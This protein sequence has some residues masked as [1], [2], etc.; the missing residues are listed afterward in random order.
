MLMVFIMK[1]Q[2][3][4]KMRDKYFDS[5]KGAAILAVVFIHCSAS[6]SFFEPGSINWY[7]GFLLRQTLNFAVPVFLVFAGF[8]AAQKP[9]T[10]ATHFYL[11]RLRYMV[12]AYLFWTLICVAIKNPKH[13][14]SP[15]ELMGDV[16]LGQGIG[17]GYFVVVLI[18]FTLLHP[19]LIK[20]KGLWAQLVLMALGFVLAMVLNYGIRINHPN[21]WLAQFPYYCLPFI[22][23]C[24][25]YQMGLF[26]AQQKKLGADLGLGRFAFSSLAMMLTVFIFASVVE[27][28]YWAQHGHYSFGI[29]QIK[30]SGFL[31]ST[32]WSALALKYFK[33]SASCKGVDILLSFMFRTC[34][35]CRWCKAY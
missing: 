32:V 22:V 23:W 4:P 29:S 17:I 25:F 5:W 1:T 7:F 2:G 15:L 28:I 20:I 11:S 12:P 10:N 6:T 31:A 24:P 30:V 27:G 26:L 35:L 3:N 33:N 21:H 34:F 9:V 16:F 18:Q 19:Y 8:F 13:L 14:L